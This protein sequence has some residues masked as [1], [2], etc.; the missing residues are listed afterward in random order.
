MGLSRAWEQEAPKARDRQ[1]P[2]QTRALER[3]VGG[4]E[5]EVTRGEKTCLSGYSWFSWAWGMLQEPSRGMSGASRS[6]ASLRICWS[7]EFPVAPGLEGGTCNRPQHAELEKATPGSSLRGVVSW[8]C[9]SRHGEQWE[10][11]GLGEGHMPPSTLSPLP[12]PMH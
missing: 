3:E 2:G 4:R 10:G 7:K 5:E 6:L 12:N 11:W 1:V 9:Y 8:L